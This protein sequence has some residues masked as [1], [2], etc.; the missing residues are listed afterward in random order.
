VV[1]Q[2]FVPGFDELLPFVLVDVRLEEDD[3]RLVGRLIDDLDA[4][5]RVGADVGVV[6][7]DLAPGVSIP[8]FARVAP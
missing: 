2:S 8:A 1:H 7:E 4:P 6:F 5:L 3:V